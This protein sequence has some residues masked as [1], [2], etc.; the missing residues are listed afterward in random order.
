MDLIPVG[1]TAWRFALPPGVDPAAAL[2][3]LRSWPRV[4]DVIVADRNVLVRFDP[5]TPPDDP[6]PA[7][8]D[9][10]PLPATSRTEHTIA[11]RYDGPDLDLVAARTGLSRADVIVLHAGRSYAVEMIGFLPGFAYLGPLDPRLDVPRLPSP[12]PRVPAGAIG[13]ATGRTGIYP[14]ASPGGWNLIATAVS[15]VPFDTRSGAALRVGDSVRF[16]PVS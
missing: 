15:F 9:F 4:T 12:R 5:R 6:R 2:H 8:Q 13:I 16:E 1:D 11:A 3:A 7:L 14:F 10:L